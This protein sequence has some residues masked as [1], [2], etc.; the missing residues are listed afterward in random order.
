MEIVSVVDEGL[1]HTSWVVGL[2]DGTALVVDPARFP[3]R[4]VEHRDVLA[5]PSE[6]F[7]QGPSRAFPSLGGR[8]ARCRFRC[9]A[10]ASHP[11][12]GRC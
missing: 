6:A 11:R 10:G 2:G 5:K 9:R 12:G 8:T 7:A 3:D 4:L 1:G